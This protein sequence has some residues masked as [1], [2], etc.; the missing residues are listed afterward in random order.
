MSV[1][2]NFTIEY[3]ADRRE[4]LPIIADWYFREWS[5]LY[6]EW[7]V[8]DFMRMISRRIHK[9]IIPLALVAFQGPEPVGTVSMKRHD[10][11]APRRLGPWITG[12]FV[13]EDLRNK[14]IGSRLMAAAEKKARELGE[15]ALFLIT[16]R[17]EPYYTRLGWQELEHT[18]QD[19]YLITIMTKRLAP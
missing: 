1:S 18:F 8:R 17:L 10:K 19:G 12:L 11:G 14:G 9:D 13:R 4:A 3:L 15:E 2:Y 5:F 6:P 16:Y 7:T